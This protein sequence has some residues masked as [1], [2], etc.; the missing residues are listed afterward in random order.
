MKIRKNQLRKSYGKT[1]LCKTRLGAYLELTQK[2]SFFQ[3][4]LF[5]Y[6][7]FDARLRDIVTFM[8][9]NHYEN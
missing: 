5:H 3:V 6:N 9:E 4:Y 1:L 8:A 2:I 7:S